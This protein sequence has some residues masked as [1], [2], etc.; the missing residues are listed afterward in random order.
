MNISV[1]EYPAIE[2]KTRR[3]KEKVKQEKTLSLSQMAKRVERLSRKRNRIE[4][5]IDSLQESLKKAL[6]ET[7]KG[8]S[9]DD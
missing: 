1:E 4:K 5:E 2:A 6:K 3:K 9:D 7:V 8:T